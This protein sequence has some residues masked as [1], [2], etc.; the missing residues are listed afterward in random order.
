MLFYNLHKKKYPTP[1]KL[2]DINMVKQIENITK[3][4]P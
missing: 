2:L 1:A 3:F 4:N